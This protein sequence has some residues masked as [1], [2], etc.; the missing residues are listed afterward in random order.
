MI[1]RRLGTKW[2]MGVVFRRTEKKQ[3]QRYKKVYSRLRV[4]LHLFLLEWITETG[5]EMRKVKMIKH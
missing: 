5:E 1:R 4:P 3:K 2:E